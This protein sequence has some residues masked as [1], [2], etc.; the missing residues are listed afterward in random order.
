VKNEPLVIVAALLAAST[1]GCPQTRSSQAQSPPRSPEAAAPPVAAAVAP[2]V[3]EAVSGCAAGA[4][5]TKAVITLSKGGS[6][7]C[8]VD[9]SPG[10]VCVAPGGII[11]WKIENE[12]DRL[13]GSKAD[14]AFKLTRPRLRYFRPDGEKLP[15]AAPDRGVEPPSILVACDLNL[16][17]LPAG[18]TFLYCTIRDDAHEGIYKYGIDG[19]EVDP[20]DPDVEV[21]RG[22]GG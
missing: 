13:A 2:L 20:L 17:E 7:K 5:V 12:C 15:G 10:L 9:L 11:R 19:P 6:R 8:R 14:P 4:A 1:L 22:N 3:G 16:T 21:R 18:R